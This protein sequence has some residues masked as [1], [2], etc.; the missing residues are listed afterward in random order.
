MEKVDHYFIF[1]EDK[2][3]GMP[4]E[5]GP[6]IKPF[7]IGKPLTDTIEGKVLLKTGDNITT[8]DIV[9]SNAKMLPYRSNIP[10]LANFIFT[11]IIDDF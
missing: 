8:D 9:P 11:T 2:H 6:N 5:M 4:V 10:H 1:P 7:P 3:I